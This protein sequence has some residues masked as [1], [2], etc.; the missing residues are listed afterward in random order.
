MV[1]SLNQ[2]SGRSECYS[3]VTNSRVFNRSNISNVWVIEATCPMIG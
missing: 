2:I 1:L 3:R